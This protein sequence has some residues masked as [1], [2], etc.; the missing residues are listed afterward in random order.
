MYI[1]CLLGDNGNYNIVF[2]VLF[3]EMYANVFFVIS[4]FVQRSD[5]V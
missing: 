4:R 5:S 3:V 2:K 1:Y